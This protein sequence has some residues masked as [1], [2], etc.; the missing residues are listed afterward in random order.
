MKIGIIATF[1]GQQTSGAEISAYLL[2]SNLKNDHEVFVVTTK[3]TTDMPFRCYT[4]PF[5]KHLPN[6]LLLIGSKLLD[7]LMEKELCRLFKK[8]K[9][10]LI[11]VQ[12]PSIMIASIKAARRLNIPVITTIRDYRFSCNLS[13]PLEQGI[14]PFQHTK[15]EYQSW[16]KESLLQSNRPTWLTPFLFPWFYSQNKRLR[17]YSKKFDYYITVSDF[18][19]NQL[20]KAG[21]PTNKIET[22]KVQR[23]DWELLP[24]SAEKEEKVIFTAG[25][26]KAT[27]GFDF[28]IESLRLVVNKHPQVKLRIAGEGSNKEKLIQLTKKLDLENNVQFIGRISYEQMR[29]EYG[30]STFVVSPSLWPEP[31]TRIIFETFAMKKTIIAT[32]V[33]G[34]SELVIPNQ[35]GLLVRPRDNEGL[36]AA[37]SKMLEKDKWRNWLADEAYRLINKEC[38]NEKVIVSHLNV[39][40][41]LTLK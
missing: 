36:A 23:P 38:N 22:I 1:L 4:L 30:N 15:K 13:I 31:L 41:K 26:L 17:N 6:L 12:D 14:I 40:K 28:L 3:V 37:M 19:K 35:T 8:E 2:A 10:D 34:S 5:T 24:D 32:D 9:P 25:G 20:I 11:H 18:V 27:K 16:L 7:K 39:Y 21:I 29:K 33:G